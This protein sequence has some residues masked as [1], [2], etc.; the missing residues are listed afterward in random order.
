MS[1]NKRLIDPTIV[2]A[3][4]GVMGTLCVTIITLYANNFAS[5]PQEQPTATLLTMMTT[6]VVEP[7]QPTLTS[8]IV[9]PTWTASPTATLTD[10]PVPTDTVAVGDP[11]ST[12]AP[13]TPTPEA[14]FTAA[15]P[16]IGSDWANGCISV[17]W[18]PYPETIPTAVNPNGCYV[19]PV[20]EFFISDNDNVRFLAAGRFDDTQVRG[21][22]AP[23]P[24][25]GTASVNAY[26]KTLQ[27]GEVW[28]GIFSEPNLESQGMI[29]VIPPGDVRRRL[30]VQK[31]MPGQQE[32]RRTD[33]LSRNP[34]IYDVVFEFNN[35]AVTTRILSDTILDPVA[36]G[37]GSTGH[38]WLFVGFQV[39]SGNN[40]IDAEFLNLRVQGQ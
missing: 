15:P 24:A 33:Q 40:R 12:P 5:R 31:T 32:V 23:L 28:M 7:T 8:V 1:N 6:T 22:F 25:N 14:T 34:S 37:V 38:Q 4:I 19:E 10:T 11:S 2:A 29:I 13:D 3:I 20:A 36:V 17:L 26:L 9:E 18:K 39:K 30:L 21:M 16:A 27:D 35:G